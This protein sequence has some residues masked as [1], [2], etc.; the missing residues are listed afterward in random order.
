MMLGFR[1]F[2]IEAKKKSKKKVD[3]EGDGEGGGGNTALGDAYE[4]LT[5]LH[6]H[7]AS[8]SAARMDPRN[9]E[10]AE[11]IQRINAI[12]QKHDRAMAS[13]SP[14]KRKK[15][16]E[17]ARNSAR[18]YLE[19]LKSEGIN[20]EDITEVHHTNKGIDKL[21]GKK[22]RQDK[23]PP[24]I[25]VRLKGPHPRGQGPNKDLHFA[26]LKLTSGTASNNGVG[27]IDSLGSDEPD[28]HVGTKLGSVW[29]AGRK[30]AGGVNKKDMKALK[31]RGRPADKKEYARLEQMYQTTRSAVIDHHKKAFD[32]STLSQQK[33][34]LM[35]MMRASPDASYHYVV[36]ENGGKSISI[37]DHP[38]VQAVRNAKAIHTVIKGTRVHFF[39]HEGRH[40]LSVEHRATH[41]PW[42]SP[43]VNAKFESLKRKKGIPGVTYEPEAPKAKAPRK[44]KGATAP[45]PEPAPASP[46]PEST[47]NNAGKATT[48]SRFAGQSVGELH[49]VKFYDDKELKAARAG[50]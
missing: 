39:D 48:P 34:H 35:H 9:P 18:A 42:S 17:G 27:S 11:N 6:I 38:V 20:P 43:Q 36:G 44:K 29:E 4:T 25:A 22:V 8:G 23:N 45:T 49:G 47:W 7:A 10:H 31:E 30:L 33:N 41:G 40:L 3:D 32:I 37:E 50:V 12:Q 1:Q 21:I 26:S 46:A 28:N 19:S 15:V 13:L 5:A 16:I 24:D 14:E 2:L